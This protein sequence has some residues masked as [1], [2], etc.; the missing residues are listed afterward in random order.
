MDNEFDSVDSTVKIHYKH[1]IE[2]SKDLQSA[3]SMEI[4]EDLGDEVL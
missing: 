3:N 4:D 2:S 1:E